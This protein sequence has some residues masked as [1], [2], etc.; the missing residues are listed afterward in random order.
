[1]ST[2]GGGSVLG[3]SLVN[4]HNWGSAWYHEPEFEE[5]ALDPLLVSLGVCP[6]VFVVDSGWRWIHAFAPAGMDG[7]G[8]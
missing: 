2:G 1:M 5:L 7:S 3:L 4:L 6:A 8:L